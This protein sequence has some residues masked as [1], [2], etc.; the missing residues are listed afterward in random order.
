MANPAPS[1]FIFM[2]PLN[3]PSAGKSEKVKREVRS[4]VTTRTH[5][6]RKEQETLEVEALVRERWEAQMRDD[7]VN[8]SFVDGPEEKE[9]G[10]QQERIW[11]GQ[12]EY[13]ANVW[14][15]DA[16]IEERNGDFHHPQSLEHTSRPNVTHSDDLW[17]PMISAV[18][19]GP[20]AFHLH[21]LNDP[22]NEIG[23]IFHD[24]KIDALDV[25]VSIFLAFIF[26][27]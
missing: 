25:V 11:D 17:N 7:L 13:R 23:S 9:K 14:Q 12:G 10:Q 4:H 27:S 26:S 2:D 15:S 22:S 6:K 19:G 20:V 18:R 21:L 1:V 24:L 5:R 16:V 3:K 8:A